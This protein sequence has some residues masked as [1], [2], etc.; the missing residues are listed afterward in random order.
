MQRSRSEFILHL[1]EL[2]VVHVAPKLFVPGDGD[3]R[4]LGCVGADEQFSSV[5]RARGVLSTFDELSY[6]HGLEREQDG[7]VER[8]DPIVRNVLFLAKG[9]LDL[10][11]D[12][13]G[14]VEEI[15]LGV[16][17]RG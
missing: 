14:R 2:L 11:L 8:Q 4:P 10:L 7:L 16:G 12:V 17:V 15:D 5:L 6:P 1:L 13:G 9:G 3:Q